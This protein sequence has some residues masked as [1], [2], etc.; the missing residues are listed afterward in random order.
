MLHLYVKLCC[1]RS[2]YFI[3]RFS[4]FLIQFYFP[5]S[6]FVMLSL[7]PSD[8]YS[9]E[10]QLD[11]T[12]PGRKAD[13]MRQ[14]LWYILQDVEDALLS[15]RLARAERDAAHKIVD[16]LNAKHWALLSEYEAFMLFKDD[17]DV[18][19][20]EMEGEEEKRVRV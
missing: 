18:V 1:V 2:I 11:K 6:F 16:D 7:L 14:E 15:L 3:L 10:K 8:A 17:G 20:D 19:G 12:K 5:Q 13:S 4:C 9:Y